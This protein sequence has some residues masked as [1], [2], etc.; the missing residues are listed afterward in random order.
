MEDSRRRIVLRALA[1]ATSVVSDFSTTMHAATEGDEGAAVYRSLGAADDTPPPVD[2]DAYAFLKNPP[3]HKIEP[4]FKNVSDLA[5][6]VCTLMSSIPSE[7]PVPN[8]VGT[9]NEESPHWLGY[10]MCVT[11][12]GNVNRLQDSLAYESGDGCPVCMEPLVQGAQFTTVC[13]H[14]FCTICWDGW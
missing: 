2:A 3:A 11:A 1:Q 8:L 5:D 7:K 13:G 12:I 10:E 4:Y 9:I 14:K 6:T